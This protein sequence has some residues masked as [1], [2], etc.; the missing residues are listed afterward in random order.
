MEIRLQVH[1]IGF[2]KVSV[3]LAALGLLVARL[4]IHMAIHA[5]GIALAVLLAVVSCNAY[6]RD[7]RP[8]ILL[9]TVAFLFLGVQQVMEAF[10]SLGFAI[11]NTPVPLVGIEL[12]HVVSFGAILFFAAG[13]LKKA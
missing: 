2:G 5:A 6:L 13:V 8:K 12:M 10:E 4:D 9:L 1:L 7:R 3:L 11:V